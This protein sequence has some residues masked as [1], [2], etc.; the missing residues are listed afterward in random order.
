MNVPNLLSCFRILL[1]PV[2]VLLFFV[3]PKEQ[4][5]WL[6][7]VLVVSGLTDVLD[8]YIARRFNQITSLGKVLDPIADKLTVA[9]VL[10]CL[11]SLYRQITVTLVVYVAKELL[12]GLG[13]LILYRRGTRPVAARWFGKLATFVTYT[14]MFLLIIIPQILDIWLIVCNVLVIAVTLF[15]L[16]MYANEFARQYKKTAKT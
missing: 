10:F 6:G 13:G 2:F 12:M 9:V 15:A 1:I 14:V 8:G 16:V 11:V 7:V 3:L 5:Y 4:Y